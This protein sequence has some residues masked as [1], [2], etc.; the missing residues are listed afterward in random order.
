MVGDLTSYVSRNY[1]MSSNIHLIHCSQET[2]V[3]IHV[4]IFFKIHPADHNDAN[5]IELGSNSK[6]VDKHAAE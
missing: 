1:S 2:V 3:N 5:G 4:S 6:M